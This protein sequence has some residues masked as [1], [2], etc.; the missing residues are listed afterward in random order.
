M[1][2]PPIAALIVSANPGRNV[3]MPSGP[4]E[5]LAPI[6]GKSILSWVV[7]ATLGAS[8]RRVAIVAADHD[9]ATKAELESRSDRAMIEFVTPANDLADSLSFALDRLGPDLT[10]RDKAHAL[11]LPGEAPQIETSELRDLIDEHVDS[12]A[13][14]TL[15][16]HVSNEDSDGDPVIT[17]DHEGRVISI[18]DAPSNSAG[19]LC[20]NASMLVPALRR[21]V[22]P[23]WQRTVPL[24]EIVSVLDEAG[25]SVRVIPRSEPLRSIWSAATRTPIEMALHDRVVAGWRERGTSMPDPRQISIDATVTLGQGVQIL[26]GSVVQ[27]SSVV[28]DGAIIGPNTQ[29]VNALIGAKARVPHSVVIDAEVRAREQLRPFSVLGSPPG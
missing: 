24:A 27:G 12:G 29:L 10:L 4:A 22:S 19:I 16:G 3:K 13:A 14:A 9:A 21:V 23:S 17:R 18:V 5:P 11:I 28:G 2:R 8:I 6:A 15:L 7:D 25:H 26:P 20:I 1:E